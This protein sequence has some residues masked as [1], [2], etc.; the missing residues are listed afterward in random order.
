VRIETKTN[1]STNS[2]EILMRFL[3]GDEKQKLVQI[4]EKI[5][6]GPNGSVSNGKVF[7]PDMLVDDNTLSL[8]SWA[9]MRR[10]EKVFYN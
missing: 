1:I 10:S 6:D 5:V 2:M 4:A 3:S 9:K 8:K 7:V